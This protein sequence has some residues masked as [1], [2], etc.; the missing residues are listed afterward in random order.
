MMIQSIEE[1]DIEGKKLLIRV[2]F[3][4]PP[5]VRGKI[6][7]DTKLK[8]ALPT[9]RYAIE[10]SAKVILASHMGNAGGKLNRRF[11]LEPIGTWLSEKLGCAIYFPENS[12]GNAVKKIA[13]DM[14]PGEV[15]L[16]ENLDFHKG[17]GQNAS[18]YAKKLSEIAD[19]YVNEAFSLSCQER[20]SLIPVLD[21]FNEVCVGLQFKKELVN[22][23]K[24]KSPEK[25]FVMVIGGAQV[26]RKIELMDYFLE[27]VDSYIIGGIPANT[28]LNIIGKD[29]GESKIDKSSFYKAKKI[30]SS[31]MIRD[32]RFVVPDDVVAMRRGLNNEYSSFIIS[33]SIIPNDS[34]VVDIG[35]A[36]QEQFAKSIKEAATVLW[37][38]PLGMYEEADFAK[39][40]KAVA[41]AIMSSDAFSIVLGDDTARAFDEA[42]IEEGKG[43][44]SRG[45]DTAIDYI[46]NKSLPVLNALENWIK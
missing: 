11:T 23:D 28:F 39:G 3:D 44:V 30:M 8:T 43:F 10:N 21:Y 35:M 14:Q 33:G 16:L 45:G 31:S 17:E 41:E 1:L 22:L 25:P 29:T 40:T 34:S 42:G 32:I 27:E 12:V 26:S 2:D 19:I 38:G 7:D 24:I 6:T 36:T 18:E 15:M 9:I 46:E 5:P 20:A 4:I 13:V 37:N